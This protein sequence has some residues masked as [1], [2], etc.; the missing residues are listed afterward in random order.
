MSP[1]ALDSIRAVARRHGYKEIQFNETSRVVAFRDEAGTVR[2]NVYYTTGT[3]ATCIDHPKSGKTQLF[4]RNMTLDDLDAIFANVR[5]HTGAGYYRRN[6]GGSSWVPSGGAGSIGSRGEECD[7]AKRWRY[8]HAATGFCNDSQ[9]NQIAALCKL[10]DNLRFQPGQTSKQYHESFDQE[11]NAWLAS[12]FGPKNFCADACDPECRCDCTMRAGAWCNLYR[13]I[14]KVAYETEGVRVIYTENPRDDIQ[15]EIRESV[16]FQLAGEACS[17]DCYEGQ[18]FYNTYYTMVA[19]LYRQLRSFPKAIRR[20][21]LVWFFD[22]LTGGQS[23]M[24]VALPDGNPKLLQEWC[25]NEILACHRDYGHMYYPEEL[26]KG[27][28]CYGV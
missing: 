11:S 5:T 18:A 12:L 27:C 8:V 21:L 26:T 4:R 6:N 1:L 24:V 15:E 10:W 19:K 2:V 20:E 17:C 7:D 23:S 13:L 22:K 16:K 25:S 3:V 9:V 28:F 14:V